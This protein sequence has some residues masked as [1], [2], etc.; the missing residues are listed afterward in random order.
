[1]LGAHGFQEKGLSHAATGGE[2][3]RRELVLS[4]GWVF[5]QCLESLV[6]TNDF[7]ARNRIK[8]S[9]LKLVRRRI[10]GRPLWLY[11]RVCFRG[12]RLLLF[13]SHQQ[14]AAYHRVQGPQQRAHSH[15]PCQTRGPA[16]TEDQE[17][18]VLHQKTSS[19]YRLWAE[20]DWRFSE[21]RHGQPWRLFGSQRRLPVWWRRHFQDMGVW[22]RPV[23]WLRCA[24]NKEIEKI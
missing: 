24:Y 12:V 5:V 3:E 4:S 16:K 1:M 2:E 20:K 23:V 14:G 21:C 17:G 8:E 22:L 18:L 7:I 19:F 13:S 15:R 9:K 11:P 10:K 6:A